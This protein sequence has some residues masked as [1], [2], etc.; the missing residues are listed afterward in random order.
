MNPS[1]TSNKKQVFAHLQLGFTLIWWSCFFI[2]PLWYLP[3]SNAVRT[4]ACIGL[5]VLYLACHTMFRVISHYQGDWGN[6]ALEKRCDTRFF[7]TLFS[8]ASA[9]HLPFLPWPILT[10][11]DTIDHAAIPAEI[12]Q[13]IVRGLSRTAGF[14]IQPLLA[15]LTLSF[16]LP[17]FISNRVRERCKSTFSSIAQWYSNHTMPVLALLAGITF[18]YAYFLL[19]IQWLERFDD[20]NPLFRYPPLSKFFSIPLYICFGLHE[21]TGRVMQIGFTFGMAFYLYRLAQFYGGDAAGKT[22]AILGVFLPPVFHYGNTTMIEGGTLFFIT[23]SFFYWIRFIECK[24]QSDLIR[25]TLFATL[26]CLYKHPGVSLIPAFAFMTAYDYLFPLRHRTSRY[27]FPSILACSIPAITIVSF[28]KLSGFNTD[29]PSDLQLPGLEYFWGNIQVI[30]KGITFPVSIL[31]GASFVALPFVGGWRTF[32]IFV[33]WIGTHYLLTC[34][35]AAALNVRQALPYY[36]GLIVPAALLV[37]SCLKNRRSL[38]MGFIYV[39]L[40]IYLL[41]ACLWMDRNQDYR[42]I[43][44]AMGDRSYINFSNWQSMYLPYPQTIQKL[45]EITTPG[46][47]IYAPMIN[48]PVHFYLAKYD[49]R[50]RIYRRELWDKLERLSLDTLLDYCQ[51][52]EADWLVIPRGRW[53]YIA[54]ADLTWNE[55][56]FTNPPPSLHP[57]EIVTMGNEQLGIWKINRINRP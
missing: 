15:V 48:E 39:I 56:I 52:I 40:P 1:D 38:Q 22:A 10:G 32:W 43:G 36:I 16:I 51:Q 33:G 8:V 50:D 9:A 13:Q 18:L 57:I 2:Y 31:F 14:S 42:T 41:W 17:I 26:A 46:D 25:G 12:A 24:G 19:H 3:A 21:W 11:L 54:N 34:M 28:M 55:E 30:P 5:F 29:V 7:I 37:E 35:S 44:R 49:L 53:L 4:I 27:L 45:K 47:V 23:A 20:L 6:P